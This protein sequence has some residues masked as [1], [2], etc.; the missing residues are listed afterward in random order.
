MNRLHC[1]APT[2]M[3]VSSRIAKLK[4]EMIEVRIR[5]F[6]VSYSLESNKRYLFTSILLS[7][8]NDSIVQTISFE[9]TIF[10][11]DVTMR[12]L[13]FGS[14]TD[15]LRNRNQSWK[16]LSSSVKMRETPEYI[17]VFELLF[18]CCFAC[19]VYGYMFMFW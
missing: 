13:S 5:S 17:C 4:C 10:W 16:T 19:S 6:V 15:E 7:R 14:Y 12:R 18:V 11:S 3:R 1:K 9:Q 8:I 2:E